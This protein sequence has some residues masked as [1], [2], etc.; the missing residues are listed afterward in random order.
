MIPPLRWAAATEVP[1]SSST[2]SAT[3]RYTTNGIAPSIGWLACPDNSEES[4]HVPGLPM[5][6]PPVRGLPGRRHDE[7]YT[8]LHTS[9]TGLSHRAPA[10]RLSIEHT[11]VPRS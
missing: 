4:L 3:I 1:I 5:S 11:D 7:G 9:P 10:P 2:P 8:R 6:V